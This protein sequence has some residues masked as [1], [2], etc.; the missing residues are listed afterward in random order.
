[1]KCILYARVSSKEQETEGF[2]I[3]AQQKLL[4]DYAKTLKFDIAQEFVDVET[5][6][7]SGR[8]KFGEM[9]AYL[10][11]NRG[12]RDV[13]VEKTDRLYRNFKDFVALDEL[14]IAIHLVKE[15]E[16][17]SKDSR[18]HAKFIHGIKL[19]MAKN[20][21]DNLSEEV[22]KGMREKAE[23]GEYPARAPLGY[24][25]D[26]V[27]RVVEPDP[28]YS[29]MIVRMFQLYATGNRSL[30][31]VRDTLR[32]EGWRTPSG[33]VFSKS[34]VEMVL[35][36]PFYHGEF[37]W[38]GGRYKGSHQ[39]LISRDLFKTVQDIL[40]GGQRPR[41]RGLE[42]LFKGFLHCGS[43]GCA[44]VAER[45]KGKYVYYHCTH[46]RGACNQP[47]VKEEALD[48]QMAGV[49]KAIEID[50]SII[51]EIVRAL[52][53][54]YKD[55]QAFRTAELTRLKQRLDDLQARL[56]KAYEDRLDG[57][58]DERYWRDVSARWR[59]DQDQARDQL[60]R[61]EGAARNY[62]DEALEILELSK[63]AYSLYVTQ[64]A[65]EKR[66]LL[67][68]VLSNCTL[69]SVTLNPT[70]KKPFN[71]IAE[72]VN[73]QSKLPRLDSNQRPAD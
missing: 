62:V 20:Y 26:K 37:I 8:T 23:Q 32:D 40:T 63:R 69:D 3:P 15:N 45:K 47:W 27:A 73:L 59:S 67:K 9:V 17:I 48:E 35:K 68:H 57:V 56:D 34:M 58:I 11:A 4:R 33:H 14:D 44:I 12:V 38:N 39:P 41:C 42:F 51:S 18:S 16:I 64:T 1:M 61:F 7:T 22:K 72:G 28:K 71:L 43:C 66:Q 54:G 53:D 55:E 13:L 2:S 25:N 5:A 19:L 50:D 30:K 6:K 29:A 21:I 52:K 49:F 46:A 24:V 65:E 31:Q 10:K 70:Y 60:A 36:N